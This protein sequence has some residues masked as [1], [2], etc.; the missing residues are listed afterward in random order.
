MILE[1]LAEGLARWTADHPDWGPGRGWEETVSSYL[2]ETDDAALFI[3]PLVADGDWAA[4][5]E[6]IGD[7]VPVVLLTR[8]GHFR[9]SQVLADRYGAEVWG[10]E[11]AR[12]RVAPGNVFNEIRPGAVVPGGVTVLRADVPG[13]DGAPLY[14]PSHAA[15]AVGDLVISVGGELRIWWV[16][17]DE[18]DRRW[19]RGHVLPALASWLEHPIRHVLVAH[20]DYVAGGSEALGKALERPP[21]D[22]S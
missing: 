9:S 8:A 5:D 1:E 10:H 4:I 13:Y 3:D 16:A 14:L 7:R 12:Q 21:W 22:V 17:E 19:Y 6:R 11:R 18:E 15:V 2:V 20:G